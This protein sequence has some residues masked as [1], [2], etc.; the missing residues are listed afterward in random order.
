MNKPQKEL[1]HVELIENFK[2]D[3]PEYYPDS[4]QNEVVNVDKN[5]PSFNSEIESNS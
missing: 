1:S 3:Y 4:D 5:D 2:R